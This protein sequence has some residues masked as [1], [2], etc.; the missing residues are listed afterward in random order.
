M[1][2]ERHVAPQRSHPRPPA[3]PGPN[4][5]V[6]TS[7]RFSGLTP[8]SRSARK[9]LHAYASA[10]SQQPACITFNS[11]TR[12][13][14]PPTTCCTLPPA[15]AAT[16][17][18]V[19]TLLPHFAHHPLL[20]LLLVPPPATAVIRPLLMPRRAAL[21]HNPLERCAQQ[22]AAAQP[23][24]QA[25]GQLRHLSSSRRREGRQEERITH[26]AGSGH[27]HLCVNMLHAAL[28]LRP[29]QPPHSRGREKQQLGLALASHTQQS[30]PPRG[31]VAWSRAPR[32]A[33]AGWAPCRC[34]A[35]SC[36]AS[37]SSPASQGAADRQ[38]PGWQHQRTPGDTDCGRPSAR[39][40]TLAAQP[41]GRCRQPHAGN[42]QW[43]TPTCYRPRTHLLL[44][45]LLLVALAV[46]P[47]AVAVRVAAAATVSL[48][49]ASSSG[50]RRA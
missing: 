28:Q 41:A 39:N 21:L 23:S 34:C 22:A 20:L 24:A 13:V 11:A 38:I 29:I 5:L 48:R 17:P 14:Q 1:R 47:P 44:L 30:A 40:Q 42:S 4:S 16:P 46:A 32:Q 25:S 18:L 45:A 2:P 19:L 26:A 15:A 3:P 36:A 8:V 27:Q 10:A 33:A 37:L 35:P 7:R 9:S 43:A 50:C 31:A 49:R 12:Q 6:M